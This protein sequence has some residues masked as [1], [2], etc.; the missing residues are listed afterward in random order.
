MMRILLPSVARAASQ[1]SSAFLSLK[2]G[3]MVSVSGGVPREENNI[4]LGDVVAACR[5]AQSSTNFGRQFKKDN[6][7]RT[8]SLNSTPNVLLDAVGV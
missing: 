1:M 7:K 4:Q 5:A 3:L 6:L 2:F 8:G